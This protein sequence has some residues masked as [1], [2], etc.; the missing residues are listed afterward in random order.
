MTKRTEPDLIRRQ[1]AT[2]ETLD[3]F[4]G[5]AWSWDSGITCAHLARFHLRAMGH[6]PAALPRLRSAIAA[7]RALT[8][9]G[10]ANVTAMLDAQPGLIRIPPAA[11][12]MGDLAALD[13]GDGLGG[14]MVCLGP[15]KLMGWRE[16]VPEMVVL[17]IV[18]G[19]I[20]AA[21]RC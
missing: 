19:E 4:R 6:K 7:R 21:W 13:S 11:M 5:V 12:K 17:D 16:D 20:A 9:R 15:H 14:V 10:W 18:F 3:R 2:Q 8:Q 1:R